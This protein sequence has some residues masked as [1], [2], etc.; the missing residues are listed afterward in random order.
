[1]AK[2]LKDPFSCYQYGE[3]RTG[4]GQAVEFS[5][6]SGRIDEVKAFLAENVRTIRPP[7]T[8]K[9]CTEHGWYGGYSRYALTQHD[10][11]GGRSGFIEALEIKDA[12]E[13]RCGF[14]CYEYSSY[15]ESSFT[16]WDT[17]EHARAAFKMYFSGGRD[18][19]KK[20]AE[21]P[22]FKRRVLCGVMMPWFYAIGDEELVGDYTFPHGL[23][24][25]GTWYHLVGVHDSV[26]NTNTLIINDQYEDS[27]SSVTDQPDTT[28]DFT[29][30]AFSNSSYVANARVDAVG[31]WSRA[32]T[33][34]EITAL[35]NEG[36][37]IELILDET[38]P[39]LTEEIDIPD[40]T[41][42]EDS[43]IY[44]FSTDELCELIVSEPTSDRGPVS[45]L[46]EEVDAV[47]ENI[48]ITLNGMETGGTYSF[49]F[50]C[51]DSYGN[52]SNTL[53]VGPFTVGGAEEAE[54]VQEQTSRKRGTSVQARVENLM[55]L[56][57]PEVAAKLMDE[58]PHLF[59]GNAA[60]V[61]TPSLAFT[62]DLYIGVSGEDV[63]Q[64]QELLIAHGYQIPA[65]A[66]GY[67]GIQTR[68]ALA[69]FQK[70]KGISPAVGY[71]GPI[72][73]SFIESL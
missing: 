60:A 17:V 6:P 32:L 68:A 44:Y 7:V 1:M 28:G 42:P 9:V 5:C 24:S 16:E 70:S 26:A 30:G 25:T 57:N 31:L 48:G 58:Y 50:H 56:G 38:A 8:H 19:E 45:V 71:F 47:G 55:R 22:G 13:N 2:Q 59:T 69:E 29:I 27:V 37:G 14:V 4:I 67:F 72:T 52:E 49:S 36:D 11:D 12:P 40:V 34:S 35:Y 23:P 20:I 54:E 21:L 65:G 39:V 43:G 10:Y 53:T 18:R 15:G 33:E 62:R 63:T 41:G 3:G 66:T 61:K 46:A 51:V 73:R 64:L